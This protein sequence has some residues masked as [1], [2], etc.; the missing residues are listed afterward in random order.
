[1]TNDCALRS[2][3]SP[4]HDTR[5]VQAHCSSVYD[6]LET[7]PIR[8]IGIA[9]PKLSIPTR[10]QRLH[11]VNKELSLAHND[12][13][14]TVPGAVVKVMPRKPFPLLL[15]LESLCARVFR[16]DVP[17]RTVKRLRHLL[18]LTHK[19]KQEQL[20]IRMLHDKPI[21]SCARTFKRDPP[22]TMH[23]NQLKTFRHELELLPVR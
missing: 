9:D 11:S 7:D 15:S 4:E 2:K 17:I 21:A 13:R 1:M 16:S 3:C 19:S 20:K 12:A 5:I 23:E 6:R 8:P 22:V 18:V 10:H 14:I